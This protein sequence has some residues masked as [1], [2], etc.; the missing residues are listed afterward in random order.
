MPKSR[1][2]LPAALAHLS[3]AVT[4]RALSRLLLVGELGEVECPNTFGAQGTGELW[5]R[6]L[7]KPAEPVSLPPRSLRR[8]A[9]E[10]CH[11]SAGWHRPTSRPATAPADPASGLAQALKN[12][13]LLNALATQPSDAKLAE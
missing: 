6:P 10:L 4:H 2:A 7:R 13:E 11:G 9:A 12:V 8:P 5:H 3:V 1:C